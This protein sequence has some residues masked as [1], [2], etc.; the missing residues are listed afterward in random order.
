VAKHRV[1]NAKGL[2]YHFLQKDLREQ[3]IWLF[4]MLAARLIS[5]LGIWMH[6]DVYREL[7][8]LLPYAVRDPVVRGNKSK[9]IEDMWGAP[10]EAGYL[11]DDN[12]LVKN[13]PKSL[14]VDGPASAPYRGARIGEGFVAAHVWRT[15]SDEGGLASRNQTTYSFVPNLLWLPGEIAALTDR[16]GSFAQLY[17]QALA[18]KLYRHRAVAPRLTSLVEQ[19]WALLPPAEGVPEQGLP[20]TEELNFFLPTASWLATRK[21]RIELI[22]DALDSASRGRP[23]SEVGL[24]KRYGPGLRDVSPRAAAALRDKLR[25]FL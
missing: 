1:V 9:G 14:S 24:S 2:L 15:L 11:R 18:Q 16:E 7:P 19:A 23:I 22:A 6:P 13:L 20:A 21:R 4:Q 5:T 10:N 25:L 17:I 12:S 3:D 8:V